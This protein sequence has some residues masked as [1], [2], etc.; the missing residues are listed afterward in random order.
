ME[1]EDQQ[2][3]LQHLK[4]KWHLFLLFSVKMKSQE[5]NALFFSEKKTSW[6]IRLCS[7]EKR[8]NVLWLPLMGSLLL[9]TDDEKES[10]LSIE[11]NICVFYVSSIEFHGTGSILT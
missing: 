9:F 7:E 4:H 8:K 2:Q 10:R 6:F 3:P 1:R 5:G 11:W